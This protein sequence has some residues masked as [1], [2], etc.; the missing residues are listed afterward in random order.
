MRPPSVQQTGA[1]VL[2]QSFFDSAATRVTSKDEVET[3]TFELSEKLPSF[4]WGP[5]QARMGAT[6]AIGGVAGASSGKVAL[7][8]SRLERCLTCP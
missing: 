6:I 3:D 2:G 7:S 8:S 5:R 1:F 4:S